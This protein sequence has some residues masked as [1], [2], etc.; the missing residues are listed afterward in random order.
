M[1]ETQFRFR[2]DE[3][4]GDP[5]VTVDSFGDQTNA[6]A[7]RIEPGDDALGNGRAVGITA[8]GE[9]ASAVGEQGAKRIGHGGGWS[10]RQTAV[11]H[12]KTGACHAHGNLAG[13]SSSNREIGLQALSLWRSVQVGSGLKTQTISVAGSNT[14]PPR[15]PV[16]IHSRSPIEN[17]S[18]PA[19]AGGA[20]DGFS[21]VSH[22]MK[23]GTVKWFDEAKGFGF[24]APSDGTG[25]VFVHYSAI[26]G[27]GFRTLA[28]GQKVQFRVVQGQKGLQAANI[29]PL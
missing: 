14:A 5:A 17:A 21:E 28:E 18:S 12:S 20:P 9:Q 1:V 16:P 22:S 3:P 2:H 27:K 6:S 25:D 29:R 7:V 8:V 24:I 10:R 13:W 4:A 26:E 19:T 23:T 11:Q 15:P